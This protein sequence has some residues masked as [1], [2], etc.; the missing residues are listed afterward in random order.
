MLHEFA[1]KKIKKSNNRNIYIYSNE[2]KIE[3]VT[4]I[5]KKKKYEIETYQFNR[6]NTIANKMVKK[7]KFQ[8]I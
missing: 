1:F 4:K 3:T 6:L 2:T 8:K 5:K 7:K